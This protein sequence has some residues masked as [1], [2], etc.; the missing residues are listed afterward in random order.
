MLERTLSTNFVPGSNLRGEVSGA[1]W[2]FALP[3]LRPGTVLCLGAPSPATARALARQADRLIVGV[4]AG[5]PVALPPVAQALICDFDSALPLPTGSVNLIVLRG[6]EAVRS[7]SRSATLQAE[8]RRVLAPAGLVYVETWGTPPALTGLRKAGRLWLTPLWGEMHTA[9][10]LHDHLTQQFFIQR[11]LFSPALSVQRLKRLRAPKDQGESVSLGQPETDERVV[12]R[13][14]LK[15]RLRSLTG[16]VERALVHLEGQWHRRAARY[17]RLGTVYSLH[18]QDTLAEPPAYL[19][20]LAAQA[21]LALDGYRWGLWAGGQYSSRKVLFYLFEGAQPSPRLPGQAGARR[22]LQRPPGERST[23]APAIARL[24]FWGASS[25]AAGELSPAA[26]TTCSWRARRWS[27][28]SPFLSRTALTPT[29]PLAQA[30]V[31]WLTDL[32]AQTS[33]LAAGSGSRRSA[34]TAF[35]ALPGPLQ[36]ARCRAR[37]PGR[38]DCTPGRDRGTVPPGLSARR[39]WPL[40]YAGCTGWAHRP[41]GLGIRRAAGNA[42]MGFALL[43]ALLRAQRVAGRGDFRPAGRSR[44]AS[45][46]RLSAQ[47]LD[48]QRCPRLLRA[49]KAWQSVCRILILCL[50]DASRPQADHAI[51]TRPPGAGS[52][53]AVAAAL[54]RASRCTNPSRA[55]RSG[56]IVR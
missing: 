24:G 27:R 53:C 55:V 33:H 14:R 30:A 15:H 21:G 10:P 6:R 32:G 23:R 51:A 13:S 9:V 25:A 18:A 38:A 16:G 2:L 40:E 12:S 20:A 43:P 5:E 19:R 29:C 54:D 22:D 46:G 56:R 35:R 44:A 34:T 8:I 48:R 4:V 31:A 17:G 39:P 28:A 45:A 3:T 52:L 41:A 49:V 7:A 11:R 26:R 37:L 1:N 42:A 50:L 47:R 36:P